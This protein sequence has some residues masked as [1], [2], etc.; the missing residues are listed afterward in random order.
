MKK[1]EKTNKE[2]LCYFKSSLSI[3]FIFV[4]FCFVLFCFVWFFVCFFVFLF[5][6]FCFVLCFLLFN[7][8]FFQL[9]MYCFLAYK[10]N[11]VNSYVYSALE[12]ISLKG[13]WTLSFVL[14]FWLNFINQVNIDCIL[15][16]TK[17]KVLK[18]PS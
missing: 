10:Q 13:D 1:Q 17:I 14:F 2:N 4:W 6:L 18:N 3:V 8:Y 9:L 7:F 15:T 5:L 12:T 11:L 16:I